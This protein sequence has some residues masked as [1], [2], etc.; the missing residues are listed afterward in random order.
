[1]EIRESARRHGI[2]DADIRHAVEHELYASDVRPDE[3]PAMVLY[4]G[5]D[6]AG[7]LL[8]VVVIER[9]ESASVAI[10]AMKMR[11]GYEVFLTGRKS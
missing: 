1:M 5:P 8:E 2:V 7:N 10:H 11:K 3:A 4:I 9:T 6:R